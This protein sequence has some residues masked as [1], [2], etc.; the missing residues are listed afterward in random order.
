MCIEADMASGY[1]CML[2]NELRARGVIGNMKEV[3]LIEENEKF[4]PLT[5]EWCPLVNVDHV[6]KRV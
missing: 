1:S 2:N 5:P 4:Q 3:K 6:L